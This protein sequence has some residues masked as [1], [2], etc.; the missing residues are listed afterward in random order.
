MFENYVTDWTPGI[1]GRCWNNAANAFY[2][3]PVDP[4]TLRVVYCLREAYC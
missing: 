2:T 4:A 1:G 3:A